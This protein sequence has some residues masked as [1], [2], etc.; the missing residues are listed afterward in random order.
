[1][2]DKINLDGIFRGFFVA[3]VTYCLLLLV[4]KYITR[5]VLG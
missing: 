5:G 1:M 3:C 2:R 4:M